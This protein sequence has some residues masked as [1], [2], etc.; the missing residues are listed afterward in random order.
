MSA[1]LTPGVTGL[2]GYL[3]ALGMAALTLLL[4]AKMRSTMPVAAITMA[5]VFL[6][7]VIM[8]S[9]P[10]AKVALL[11]PFSGLSYAFDSMVS[12]V[13]GPLVV[14]PPTAPATIYVAMLV[15]FTPLAIQAFRRHQVA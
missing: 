14:D 11:T 15:V 3:I 4:S 12:H 7:I 6:G 2:L 5:I 8:F 9:T 10:L 13:F 1:T